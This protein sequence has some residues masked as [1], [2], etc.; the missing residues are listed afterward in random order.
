MSGAALAAAHALSWQASARQLL[1]IFA[2][3]GS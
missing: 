2:E 1:A 3:V